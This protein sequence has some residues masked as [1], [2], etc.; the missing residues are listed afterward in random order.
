MVMA[1]LKR[2]HMVVVNDFTEMSVTVSAEQGTRSGL[3]LV[4]LGAENS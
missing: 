3:L 4:E 2:S 1:Q